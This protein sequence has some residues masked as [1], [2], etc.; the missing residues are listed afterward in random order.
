MRLDQA[1]CSIESPHDGYYYL[2]LRTVWDTQSRWRVFGRQGSATTPRAHHKCQTYEE[3]GGRRRRRRRRRRRQDN[4]G[5]ASGHKS[6]Q[7]EELRW[8]CRKEVRSVQAT[9]VRTVG[10]GRYLRYQHE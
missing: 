1:L 7:H 2:T 10:T 9:K 3:G 6:G 4:T 5:C 8:S